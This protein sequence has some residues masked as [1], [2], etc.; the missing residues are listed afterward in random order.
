MLSFEVLVFSM[1]I[2]P[3]LHSALVAIL[4]ARTVLGQP[5]FGEWGWTGA[6]LHLALMC[7]GYAATLALTLIGLHRQR[8]YRLF[9]L[10]LLLPF[11]WAKTEHTVRAAKGVNVAS[12]TPKTKAPNPAE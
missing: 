7:F 11:Y 9:A 3:L 8:R 6:S 2:S 12:A 5:L 10:Q 4:L 1:I